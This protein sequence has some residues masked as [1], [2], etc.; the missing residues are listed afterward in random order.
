MMQSATHRRLLWVLMPL[1]LLIATPAAA[2]VIRI[3]ITSR[4]P[5]GDAVPSKIGSKMPTV[6]PAS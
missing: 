1:W 6:F 3:E 4:Q 2:E 5:F